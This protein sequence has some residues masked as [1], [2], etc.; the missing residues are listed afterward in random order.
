MFIRSITLVLVLF[1]F[2]SGISSAETNQTMETTPTIDLTASES[3][4]EVGETI[5]IEGY[6]VPSL[7]TRPTDKVLLQVTSPRDSKTDVYHHLKVNSDGVFTTE[8]L[9]DALGDWSFIARYNNYASDTVPVSVIPRKTP[10][11][12]EL[13][14]SGPFSYPHAGD[15]ARMSGWLSDSDGNGIPSRQVWYKIGLPSYSCVLCDDDSRR[16]WQTFGPISTD[17]S[18]YFE[19]TF[20]IS[21]DGQYAVRASYP[22]DEI[23][24]KG[25]SDTVYVNVN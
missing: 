19:F 24:A 3:T 21:T 7:L 11:E 22:G 17:E 14:V 15:T 6:I 8:F 5:V 13:T 23:Y 25:E 9:A 12:T 16:I 1:L 20:P 10:K 2:I 4:I 18:G